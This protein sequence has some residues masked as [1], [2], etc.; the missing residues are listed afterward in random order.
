MTRDRRRGDCPPMPTDFVFLYVTAKDKAEATAL[1][2]ALLE[3]KL[4][5]CVNVTAGMESHYWWEGKIESAT[6]AVL[7]VKTAASRVEAAT[8]VLKALH[9]YEVPCILQFRV[10]DGNPEYLR[11]LASSLA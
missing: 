5:A 10:E 8:R 2:R 4:A 1:G 9:S 6:E 7:V 11:W 3:K